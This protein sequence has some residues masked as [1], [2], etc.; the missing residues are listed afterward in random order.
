MANP[1]SVDLKG[2]TALVTGASAGIGKEI[3]RGLLGMGA[4]VIFGVRNVEKGQAVAKELAGAS[5]VMQ[6][7]TSSPA[8]IRKFAAEVKAKFPKLHILVNNAGAWYSDKRT[9]PEGKELTFATNVLGPYLL[10]EELSP[11]LKASA[12]SR[13]V[14]VVSSFASDYDLGDLEF[15]RRKYDGFKAYGQS[16][17]AARMITWGL[18][19]R[20][21]GTGVTVNAAAPGFVRTDFN[22][23]AHGFIASMINL[24]AQLFA[25]T[26]AQGGDAITW[27][28]VAPELEGQT[29]K[30]FDRR[31]EKDGKYQE[32]G[33]IAELEKALQQMA[34]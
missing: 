34:A 25:D 31:K 32:P 29:G 5:T 3:A 28:A 20:L 8:S 16:K 14:N 4:H 26:P 21:A 27:A 22:K 24:S 30:Y 33:P 12:P 10:S 23:N 7:D 2:K 13:I 9:S 17:L 1:I 19:K 15:S 11:L 6:V 18:A